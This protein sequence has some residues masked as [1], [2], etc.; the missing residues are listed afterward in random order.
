M[1]CSYTSSCIEKKLTFQWKNLVKK[2]FHSNLNLKKL[3]KKKS[4]NFFERFWIIWLFASGY[5]LSWKVLFKDAVTLSITTLGL[6]TYSILTLSIRIKNQ[7]H[8]VRR[9]FTEAA[10]HR[11]GNSP[12]AHR[13]GIS[14]NA[15]W[16]WWFTKCQ[17][18]FS[19]CL[20]Y[21]RW[22]TTPVAIHRMPLGVA[23]HRMPFGGGD[24]PNVP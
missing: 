21:I 11:N 16:G 12:N 23:F 1:L 10:I 8:M 24:S 5:S 22:I 17:G 15:L 13:D 20:W 7:I 4:V 14:L 18:W 3:L 19:H 2:M 6:L 9:V